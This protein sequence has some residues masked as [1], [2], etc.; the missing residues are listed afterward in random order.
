MINRPDPNML[1]V[2][3]GPD[4]IVIEFTGGRMNVYDNPV[5]VVT[6]LPEFP[7]H[8]ANL[9]NYSFLNNVDRNEG[10]F[11]K[12]KVSAPDRV[13][14]PSPTVLSMTSESIPRPAS[15]VAWKR[16]SSLEMTRRI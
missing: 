7:W 3:P 15:K 13:S 8:L 4:G 9:N 12:L 2:D 11:G 1:K 16:S 10:Q 6:N 14:L 5:G